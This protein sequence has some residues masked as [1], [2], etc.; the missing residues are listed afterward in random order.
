MHSR[1]QG[2][3]SVWWHSKF[4]ALYDNSI[5][6]VAELQTFAPRPSPYTY[7]FTMSFCATIPFPDELMTQLDIDSFFALFPFNKVI[8]PFGWWGIAVPPVLH[9]LSNIPMLPRLINFAHWFTSAVNRRLGGLGYSFSLP[10]PG[11]QIPRSDVLPLIAFPGYAMGGYLLDQ[12]RSQL[13]GG[14]P[15]T[16]YQR[17]DGIVNTTSMNGPVNAEY[18]QSP[19]PGPGTGRTGIYWHL[20]ENAT[21]DHADQ[22]GVFTS[23]ETVCYLF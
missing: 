7:Y 3:V 22:I 10:S 5:L 14:I 13:L 23:E 11:T 12:Q 8:N 9:F 17:N 6:G 1:L 16:E 2:L 20:G 19:F 4:H 21:I 18:G 15:S